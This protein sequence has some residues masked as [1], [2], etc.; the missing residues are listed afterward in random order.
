[1]LDTRLKRDK[2]N[3]NKHVLLGWEK[4][5]LVVSRLSYS[6]LC[7]LSVCFINPR[8]SVCRPLTGVSMQAVMSA[9]SFQHFISPALMWE[10]PGAGGQQFSAE[11]GRWMNTAHRRNAFKYWPRLSFIWDCN[12]VEL[13][14]FLMFSQ[15]RCGI[16][17]PGQTMYW[18]WRHEHWYLCIS[19]SILG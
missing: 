13:F 12:N 3:V 18:V 10:N 17:K 9:F 16:V 2:I 1:M 6:E 11:L 5:G 14:E 15:L 4:S 8:W 7:I 19:L